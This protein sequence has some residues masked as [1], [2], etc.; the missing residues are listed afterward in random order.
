M[1]EFSVLAVFAASLFF[2]ISQNFSILYALVF[3]FFLFFFYGVYKK[4]NP[5]EMF[6]LAF[7]GIKTVKNILILFVLIGIITAFWKAGGTIAYIVYYSTQI[8][9]PHFMLL[10]TFLL[11]CLISVLTGTSFGTSATMGV[12]CVTISNS[13]GIPI[14]LSGGA[15]LAGA[16]FGDRCSPMSTSALLV[17]TLTKTDIFRNIK[18]MIKTGLVPLAL[19]CI[20][21]L[22]AGIGFDAQLDTSSVRRLF[23]E[24]F[25]LHPALLIPALVIILLSLFKINVKITMSVSI[26]S[27]IL[28]SIWFQGTSW[29]EL[30]NIAIHG[31]SPANAELAGILSGGGVLSMVNVFCI[32]CI[33]SCYAGMFNG[34]G[35][36]DGIRGHLEKLSEKLTPFG[37]IM[38]TSI[39]TGIIACNQTLTIMLTHQLCCDIEKDPEEMALTLENTAVVIA[40]IIPWSI[41]GS[42]PLAAIGAPSACIIT[43]CYL[44]LIPVWNY[45]AALCKHRK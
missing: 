4:H 24:H 3:G 33:S 44:Y 14:L 38:I 27:S 12:I 32:V 22:A 10:I 2:C 39:V 1:I 34:T 40:P 23:E 19:T 18:N 6:S 31:Y 36:L 17:S 45:A 21:Y 29:R 15:V 37:S 16:F 43:A 30:L 11:C 7:S 25:V 28:I 9:N 13:M 8:F 20:I 41:A 35:L 42:V 26:I 5:K